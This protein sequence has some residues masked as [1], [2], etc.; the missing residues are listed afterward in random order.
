MVGKLN[1]MGERTHFAAYSL[2]ICMNLTN[3]IA[4]TVYLYLGT[5][6]ELAQ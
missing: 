3:D 2:K 6:F 4:V 5:V 1:E